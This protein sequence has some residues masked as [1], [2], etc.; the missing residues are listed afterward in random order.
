MIAAIAPMIPSALPMKTRRLN[1]A[2]ASSVI[3]PTAS[4]DTL[5]TSAPE[6]RSFNSSSSNSRVG[7]IEL[8]ETVADRDQVTR[9]HAVPVAAWR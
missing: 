6:T 1:A 5:V 8:Q 2:S 3:V 7:G 9:S 4:F